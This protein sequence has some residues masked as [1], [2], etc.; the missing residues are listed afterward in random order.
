MNNLIIAFT[1]P[2]QTSKL[3]NISDVLVKGES[4]RAF[5]RITD[6]KIIQSMFSSPN[7][8]KVGV[9]AAFSLTT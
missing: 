2:C 5:S 7:S 3:L 8:L 9:M 1:F 4:F 6:D